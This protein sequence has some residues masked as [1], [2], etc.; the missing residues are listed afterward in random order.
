M[1]LRKLM[2]SRPKIRTTPRHS[3]PTPRPPAMHY[4]TCQYSQI[5]TGTSRAILARAAVRGFSAI[6]RSLAMRRSLRLPFLI[7][8]CGF[9][10]ILQAEARGGG[11]GGAVGGHAGGSS[12]ARGGGFRGVAVFRGGASVAA[13]ANIRRNRVNTLNFARQIHG[14]G[15]GFRRSLGHNR[16]QNGIPLGW[17]VGNWWPGYGYSA[18]QQ[19]VEGPA[20]PEIFIIHTDGQGRTQ[21]AEAAADFSYVKGCHA[22]PNGYHCD[23]PDEDH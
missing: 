4:C 3:T 10:A 23:L 16:F 12:G 1:A 13:A 6:R 7:V 22:I 5:E 8:L 9:L 20:Q 17:P 15:L 2:H 11:G 19:P 14:D 21:T 18:D